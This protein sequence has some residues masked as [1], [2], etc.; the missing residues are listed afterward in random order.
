MVLAGNKAKHL[1]SVNHTTITIQF[2]SALR[3]IQI[4]Q[5]SI[6]VYIGKKCK[7]SLTQTFRNLNFQ[8]VDKLGKQWE[9][10]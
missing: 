7:Y 10:T 3:N 2:N 8:S 4:S 1:S 9:F 5:V 6:Y